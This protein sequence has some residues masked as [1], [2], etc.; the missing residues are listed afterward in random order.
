[1]A[2]GFTRDV[3]GLHISFVTGFTTRT[4]MCFGINNGSLEHSPTV[5]HVKGY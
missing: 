3:H 1:M 2:I 4:G 5:G